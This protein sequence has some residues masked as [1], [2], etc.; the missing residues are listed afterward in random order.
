MTGR[1]PAKPR[2]GKTYTFRSGHV[3]L[4]GGSI[5]GRIAEWKISTFGGAPRV[6]IEIITDMAG[7]A[8]FDPFAVYDPS[9]KDLVIDEK[10]MIEGSGIEVGL[11]TAE[12]VI[13]KAEQN[14]RLEQAKEIA[15][16]TGFEPAPPGTPHV[17]QPTVITDT[18]GH[19]RIIE[20]MSL[21]D[22]SRFAPRGALLQPRLPSAISPQIRESYHADEQLARR[23][24]ADDGGESDEDIREPER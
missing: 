13:A 1:K 20:P 16:I 23:A 9:T 4:E 15:A 24:S 11:T 3:M 18:D 2:P 21:F 12:D 10:K 8:F 7:L 5:I 22:T 14:V 19:T 6:T 17:T